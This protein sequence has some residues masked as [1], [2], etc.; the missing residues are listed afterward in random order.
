MTEELDQGAAPETLAAEPAGLPLTLGQRLRAAR[1][2]KG[3]TAEQVAAQTRISA[4]HIASIEADDF[5]ALASRTYAIGFTRTYAKLVGLDAES[6]AQ[7]VRRA[8]DAHYVEQPARP[9]TFEPGDPARLPS[10]ALGWISAAAVL[11]LIVAGFFLLPRFFA[12][13]AQIPSLFDQQAEEQ[14]AAA[15][16]AS[17]AAATQ[18]AAP[19]DA[20]GPVVFTAQEEGIWVKFYDAGGSQLMQKQMAKGEVYTVPA[21]ADGPQLWT[22]RPEALA[23]TVGGKPVPP[24]ATEQ[25]MVKDVPVTASALLAR[26]APVATPSAAANAT[27]D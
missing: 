26:A 8:L 9:D 21:D 23:I 11:A 10:V 22:A 18:G 4:R 2:A 19:A 5:S 25:Q 6:A 7:D 3:F 16:A 27:A 12:P 24:I 20:S 1:E 14:A 17:Q 15:A 13:A